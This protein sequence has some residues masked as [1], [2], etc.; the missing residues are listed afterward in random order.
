MRVNTCSYDAEG[1]LTS[2]VSGGATVTMQYNAL[3]QRVY[4]STSSGSVSYFRDAGGASMMASVLAFAGMN[5][6]FPKTGGHR[7]PLQRR[8]P[9]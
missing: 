9:G 4:R 7:P 6:Q 3:G 2:F 5:S 1:Q 8:M